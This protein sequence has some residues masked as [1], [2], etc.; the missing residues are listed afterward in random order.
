MG[1]LEYDARAAT[2]FVAGRH[3]DD[4]GLAAW[5]ERI[6]HH[7]PLDERAVLL[8]LGAGTGH[9]MAAFRRWY[10]FIVIGVE[11][12]PA[13]REAA[14]EPLLAGDAAAIPLA[15]NSVDAV[16]L[17]TVVHHIPDRPAAAAEIRRVLR[18][19][20]RVLIRSAFAGRLDRI[21]LFHYFPEAATALDAR[22]PS[23]ASIAAD[24][25]TAGFRTIALEPVPQVTAPTLG[26]F[27]EHLDR[28]A[29]TPLM[30]IDDA[31]YERGLARLRA[32]DPTQ[33]AVDALDLLVLR[34]C[35]EQPW[36][37]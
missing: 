37:A 4:D 6:R 24:F 11:P 28:A 10:P 27:V 12:S 19:G 5:R 3:L 26:G 13:M 18:P 15:A 17:S 7:L 29:H 36:V 33:P 32:A 22:Y 34:A 20:G 21:S 35:T 14:A 31:A 25:G 23:A 9:W 2:A 30:L 8:D 16:W 1:L